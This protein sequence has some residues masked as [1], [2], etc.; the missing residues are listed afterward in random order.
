MPA[1]A[2]SVVLRDHDHA[3]QTKME[4]LRHAYAQM[5]VELSPAIPSSSS[6]EGDAGR[7]MLASEIDAEID[8]EIAPTIPSSES[9]A[10]HSK[11]S[12]VGDLTSTVSSVSCFWLLTGIIACLLTTAPIYVVRV[13]FIVLRYVCP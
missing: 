7:P 1:H 2:R 13:R 3:G 11:S 10:H 12:S 9:D 8:S 6:S 4:A 5:D